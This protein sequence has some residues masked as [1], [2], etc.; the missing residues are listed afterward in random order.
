MNMKKALF[1]FITLT[2][3]LTVILAFLFDLLELKL[4][5][6]HLMVVPLL[7]SFFV[8]K[9]LLKRPIFGPNGL[10]FTFGKKRYLILGP[11]F[12]FLFIILVYGVSFLLNQDLFS[13]E[14]THITAE[15]SLA[16]YNKNN[17]LV[18]NILLAAF[19]QLLVAPI[20]NIILFIGE[21]VGWRSFLYP[22]LISVYGKRG[23]IF[24][25][26]I[27]GIWH[28]PM[29]YLYDLNY[30]P[31][32]HLGLIFMIVFCILA[33]VILQF[34]YFKSQSIFSV[35]LTHG[36]LNIAGGFI[37]TFTVKSEYRY[38]IDGAVGLVGLSILFFI[39]LICYQKFP[40]QQD[41]ATI[42]TNP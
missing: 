13:I 21:E 2:L 33:G 29:I 20:L 22:Y 30:G 15:Q 9:I 4:L 35:A 24:G 34:I 6:A 26:V 32:H 28:A 37:F 18:S 16:T 19:I 40:N 27:W 17:S 36:M 14:H 38:F 41:K 23:L 39:A 1:I 42:H 12:T 25:G 10:G 11:L 7:T 31:H 3:S 5:S 8:Q